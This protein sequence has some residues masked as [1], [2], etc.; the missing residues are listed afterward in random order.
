MVSIPKLR[1][2]QMAMWH[3]CT[4][5]KI[6]LCHSGRGT[7]R[8]VWN[9][10]LGAVFPEHGQPSARMVTPSSA[11]LAAHEC[12]PA[13]TP[14][15]THIPA[16][17][18]PASGMLPAS[19][20]AAGKGLRSVRLPSKFSG[21]TDPDFC[22][23]YLTPAPECPLQGSSQKHHCCGNAPLPW[24]LWR[25][26]LAAKTLPRPCSLVSPAGVCRQSQILFRA[27]PSRTFA[28]IP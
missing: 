14:V 15:C 2:R 18:A 7:T 25:A 4:P 16:P 6:P 5:G 27:C 9:H 17:L 1:Y 12:G 24:Q 21:H 11:R 28:S 19:H 8:S 20:A 10:I 26:K 13:R 22:C 3:Q 23:V